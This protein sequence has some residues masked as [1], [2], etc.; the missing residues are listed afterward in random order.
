[1]LLAAVPQLHRKWEDVEAELQAKSDEQAA[2][3]IAVAAAETDS[4]EST[5]IELEP[6]HLVRRA[7]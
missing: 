6:D 7:A 4:S 2:Y 5:L 3:A 1:M